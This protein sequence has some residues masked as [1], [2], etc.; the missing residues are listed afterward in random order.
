MEG[1]TAKG[2][3]VAVRAPELFFAEYDKS[4]SESERANTTRDV[5]GTRVDSSG[6]RAVGGLCGD[7]NNTA[8]NESRFP[9]TRI[10][11]R[12]TVLN[13]FVMAGIVSARSVPWAS[14]L[15]RRS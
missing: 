4:T 10:G 3:Y 6:S 14:S 15:N 2:V 11:A 9:D 7:A 12:T 5:S 13:E 8:R 1:R